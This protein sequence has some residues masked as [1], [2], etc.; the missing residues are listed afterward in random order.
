MPVKK[1]LDHGSGNMR[2][3]ENIHKKT[4]Q[5]VVPALGHSAISMELINVT[6]HHCPGDSQ[7]KK[8][9]QRVGKATSILHMQKFCWPPYLLQC[10]DLI[11]FR[12]LP[13]SPPGALGW[14][15][16]QIHP[17]KLCTSSLD[18]GLGG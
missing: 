10:P 13:P 2:H 1:T 12:M 17:Q 4:M 3:T 5:K 15:K 14:E 11:D 7:E 6:S 18:S 8:S 9:K 16:D